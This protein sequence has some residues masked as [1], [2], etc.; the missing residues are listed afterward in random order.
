MITVNDIY[1]FLDKI[2][3][4]ETK[5]SWDNCGILIGDGNMQVK[6]IGFTLDLTI[7]TLNRATEENVDLIITHHPVIFRPQNNFLKGNIAYETAIRGISVISSHT[8]YDC[9]DGGVSDILAKMIGLTNIETV[10]TKEKPSCLRIG[11]IKEITDED[12]AKTVSD[13]LNTT[14]RLAGGRKIIKKVA[15]CGGSG[16]DFISCALKAGADAYVTGDLSHH[17]FLTA[18]DAGL[19]IIGAGHFETENISVT[20]LMNRVSENFHDMICV[21]LEQENPVKFINNRG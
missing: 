1:T 11:D 10:E 19:T 20:P 4:F 7:E 8:C 9:A 15:V 5:C 18:K 16:G 12:L 2:A 13:K 3:P 21:Y 17:H 14:V 6:K